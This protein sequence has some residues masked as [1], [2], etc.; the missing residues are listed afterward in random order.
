MKL[1][2]PDDRRAAGMV[3]AVVV[4]LGCATV[5]VVAAILAA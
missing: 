4:T 2:Q 1:S 5:A 3:I